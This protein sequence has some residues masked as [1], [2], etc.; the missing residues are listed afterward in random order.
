MHANNPL[1]D[2]DLSPLE[3][4]LAGWQPCAA[5]LDAD[6]LLF[7]AGR[8]SAPPPRRPFVW[9]ALAGAMTVVSLVLGGWLAVERG[10]RLMLVAEL[11]RRQ[12]VESPGAAPI[13]APTG[14]E[15]SPAG[16][17]VVRNLV[18]Q[19]GLDAW[20]KP[21]PPQADGPPHPASE[22]KPIP[23]VWTRDNLTQ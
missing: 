4:R 6:A 10:E 15:L 18:M 23:Q 19:N 16:Y 1:P 14:E 3:R 5:G 20:P 21:T 2:D 11:Q 17:L 22:N 13:P 8:A 9:P 7:A 12:P